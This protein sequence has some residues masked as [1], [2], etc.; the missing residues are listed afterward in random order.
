MLHTLFAA[1]AVSYLFP[2]YLGRYTQVEPLNFH[3]I[4]GQTLSAVGLDLISSTHQPRIASTLP[5]RCPGSRWTLPLPNLTG[6]SKVNLTSVAQTHLVSETA[7][8]NPSSGLLSS[9]VP[10]RPQ[11]RDFTSCQS[12]IRQTSRSPADPCAVQIPWPSSKHL[13]LR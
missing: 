12:A 7:A 5:L 13:G 8:T 10:Q 11:A 4:H 1:S 2:T 3:L 6:Q 9:L